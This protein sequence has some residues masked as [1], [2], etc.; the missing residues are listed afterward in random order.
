MIKL[1][2]KEY[3]SVLYN[4]FL[5]C[6]TEL[7]KKGIYRK[8]IDTYKEGHENEIPQVLRKG[9]KLLFRY[10]GHANGK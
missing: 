1:L 8:Q 7:I 10:L 9:R 2:V 3:L 6:W 5:S 4:I